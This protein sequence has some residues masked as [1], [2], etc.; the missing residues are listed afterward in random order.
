MSRIHLRGRIGLLFR[1]P[2]LAFAALPALAQRPITL[3]D[4]LALRSVSAA[5]LS[6]DGATIAYVRTVPRKAFADKDGLPWAELHVCDQSGASRPY[7]TGE[8]NVSNVAWT[9]DGQSI[10]YLAKR[11]GDEERCLYAIPLGG[12]ESRRLVKHATGI[13]EYSWSPDGKAVAFV[14]TE[15]EPKRTKE[16]A[17]KGFKAEIYEE[18]PRFAKLFLARPF[19]EPAVEP[20]AFDLPGQASDVA[21]APDGKRI[22][23]ALAPT[24][25]VDDQ[26]MAR[27]V[28]VVDAE[29]GA[30]LARV[31]NPGKLGDLRWSPDGELLAMISGADESDPSTARLLV[32]PATGGKPRE[33]APGAEWDAVAFGWQDART[34]LFLADHGLSTGLHEIAADGSGFKTILA[35]GSYALGGFNLSRDGQRAALIGSSARFPSEAFAM[36]HGDAAPRRLTDSNP[37]LAE[38]RLAEQEAVDFRARDGLALQGVL[39]RPLDARPG[40]RV[41]LI[42]VAHGGPESHYRDAWLTGYSTPGQV[43]AA[44]GY[45]VFYPNYRG[46]TGRG[47]AFAKSSQGDP[48]GKEFEDLVD[49]VD[50]LVALGLVDPAKVGVTGGSYG[51]YATAW[52]ST[53]LSERFAA[54]VMMVGI[55]DLVSKAGTTDIPNEMHD[56]HWRKHAVEDW[57]L[58][59]ERSPVRWVEGA[60]TPLLI[61]HGK[62]DTRVHPAQSL[63]LY[64]QLKLHGQAPVRLVNYP[65]EGHGNR[66]DPARYDYALRMLQWF[67]HYL[68]GPGG[69][70]PPPD[71]E[72]P[73]EEKKEEPSSATSAAG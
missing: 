8:V 31:E 2:L 66:N 59:L 41:P 45:A 35:P 47:V 56:V 22:A 72:Y 23:L 43:A 30:I 1:A 60:H 65:G 38:I 39:I 16:L 26:Q 40:E 10:S 36:S 3:E 5:V 6:P 12:G 57:D 52:C 48:A 17:D 58:F 71:L 53:K 11:T 7:V 51:G 19:D 67:D 25:L 69:E 13:A 64:R 29:S 42:L 9:P 62:N 28:H 18:R 15:E 21:F 27:R 55:T 32:A 44:R 61:V 20:R 34:L 73:L 46:S 54:G 37:V 4:A 68:R 14:A 70:P 63:E 33:L 50:H 24:P 49:A